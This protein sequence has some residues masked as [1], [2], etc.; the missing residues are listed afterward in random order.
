MCLIMYVTQVNRCAKYIEYRKKIITISLLSV[1]LEVGLMIN[2][3]IGFSLGREKNSR[4]IQFIQ[5]SKQ[6]CS[7]EK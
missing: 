5:L 7:R 3:Q 1:S 4:H 2:W 6:V